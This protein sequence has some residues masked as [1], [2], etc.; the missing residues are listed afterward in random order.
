MA[1]NNIT[2]TVIREY[3][4]HCSKEELLR[5]IIQRQL[6]LSDTIFTQK[7]GAKK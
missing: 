4:N 3:K 6:E 2:W 7:E 1:Q 5:K